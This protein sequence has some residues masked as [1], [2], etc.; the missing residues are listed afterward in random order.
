MALNNGDTTTRKETEE[1]TERR[2]ADEEGQETV[3][4]MV[5]YVEATTRW[6]S[7]NQRDAD[8]E[9]LLGTRSASPQPEDA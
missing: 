1:M 6:N 2:K 4:T 5:D 3:T 8:K 9:I 7:A